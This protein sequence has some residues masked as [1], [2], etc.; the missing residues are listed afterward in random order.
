MICI[1]IAKIEYSPDSPTI[2]I[3]AFCEELK[4]GVSFQLDV[5][6]QA[7]LVDKLSEFK[8]ADDAN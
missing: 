3:S 2:T 1:K 7:I 5:V 4:S 8:E 6:D